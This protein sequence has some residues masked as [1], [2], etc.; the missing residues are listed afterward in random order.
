MISSAEPLGSRPVSRS[1]APT[2]PGMPVSAIWRAETL[3]LSAGRRAGS[4]P[5]AT[6][7]AVRSTSS[8]SSTI[9]PES[10]ATGMNSDGGIAPR[11]GWSQRSSAST[12]AIRS[13]GSA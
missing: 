3:T 9:R 13:S 6:R 12:P 11:S 5:A 7:Q 2:T 4:A 8:P 1:T 10:S